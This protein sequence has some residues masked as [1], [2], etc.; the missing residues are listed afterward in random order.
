MAPKWWMVLW[1]LGTLLLLPGFT[2][3]ESGEMDSEQ[4]DGHL[5]ELLDSDQLLYRRH[6]V[7]TRR[8]RNLLFP[9]GVK[10]CTQET[11]D[12]A[13][14]NHLTFFQQRVCQET[15]WE[16]FRIFWDRLPERDEYQDWVS[17]CMNGTISISD[18]GTFFSQS[19]E[20]KQLIR[21][22]VSMAASCESSCRHHRPSSLQL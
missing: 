16:A 10:L 17:G 19:E 1:V 22:R 6:A 21:T 9:S 11:F 20:H 14:A 18:I 5:A 8:K 13:A 3:M 2:Y 15:V 4:Q 7:L 12:Q